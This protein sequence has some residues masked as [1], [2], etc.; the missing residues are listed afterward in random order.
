MPIFCPAKT[1]LRAALSHETI[2]MQ[3]SN[4]SFLSPITTAEIGMPLMSLLP[5]SFL[6]YLSSSQVWAGVEQ[7]LT[8]HAGRRRDQIS[9][10]PIDPE[11]R[12]SGGCY[13]VSWRE[14]PNGVSK[15]KI[16]GEC[17]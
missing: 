17:V 9:L 11:L 8:I 12:I 2:S 13:C 14:R 16:Y 1:W 7:P 15:E 4:R 5:T 3:G 10:S 6:L